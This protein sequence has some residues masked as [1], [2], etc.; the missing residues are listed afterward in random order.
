MLLLPINTYELKLI[1]NLFKPYYLIVDIIAMGC[2]FSKLPVQTNTR[3]IS[4]FRF[5]IRKKGSLMLLFHHVLCDFIASASPEENHR[6][7]KSTPTDDL[8]QVF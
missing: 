1:P 3:L 4:H 8:M 6:E 2:T 5:T 7:N